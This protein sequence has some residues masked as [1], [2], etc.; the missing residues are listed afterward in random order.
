MFDL[1][2][3]VLS[4]FYSFTAIKVSQWIAISDLGF[5]LNT[6]LYFSRNS[7]I[8]DWVRLILLLGVIITVFFLTFIPWY[9]AT[10][11]LFV[12]WSGSKW[13][14]W[15]NAVKKYRRDLEEMIE[16]AESDEEKEE[17]VQALIKS[18]TDLR[19]MITERKRIWGR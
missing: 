18:E 3:V 19:N 13:I 2:F 11:C 12:I 10:I 7:H 14:G 6:P 5:S 4:I 17:Y 15:K 9:F 16:F 8:Y 1:L